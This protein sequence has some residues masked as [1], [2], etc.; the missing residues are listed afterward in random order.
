MKI[1]RDGSKLIAMVA[2]FLTAIPSNA[3]PLFRLPLAANTAVHY[4]YD[5]GGVTDWKCGGETYSGH[6]GTDFS[7]GPRGTSIYAAANGSLRERVDGYGDGYAGSPDGGGAGNHVVLDHGGGFHTWYM[8]MTVG[9]VTTKGTGSSIACSEKIGGVGTS[10]SSSGLHLHFGVYPDG[11]NYAH[12]DPYSGSCGGP[13]SYWVNQ[14]GGNPVTT[15]QGAP[16]PPP[17]SNYTPGDF[18]DDLRTDSV[19][20][21][22]STGLWK[23]RN[24]VSGAISQF[25]WGG[26]GDV[27]LIGNWTTAT[28]GEAAVWRPST[29]VWWIRFQSGV[30]AQVQWGLNGDIPVIGAWSGQMRDQ[31]VFRPSNGNWYIRFGNTGGTVSLPWGANGDIPLV[32]NWSGS[33]MVDQVMFRPSTGTWYV[34]NGSTG[35][36]SSFVWGGNGDIPLIGAWSGRMRDAVAWRPSTGVWWIR[37][38]D[39][40]TNVSFQFGLPGDMPMVGNV[41]GHGVIDQIVFRP[42]TGTW[43][44]RDGSNGAV[45]SYAFGSSADKLVHE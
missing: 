25:N 10:G 42:S 27:P 32:G 36:A 4:Y 16:P 23:I 5:H 41:F 45:W 34:R 24:S 3:S 35:A 12:D 9:S 11:V 44:V 26:T 17:P 18:S 21:T 22:P 29:G 28:S 6:N 20:W 33:G 8:H 1:H 37:F 43:Y 2:G 15:C 39:T 40:G 19:L 38:G 7:G 14:N 13:I 31:A 30:N